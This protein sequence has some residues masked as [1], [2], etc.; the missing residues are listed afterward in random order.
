M[1]AELIGILVLLGVNLLMF[2]A[3]KRSRC[4]GHAEI[5]E[6]ISQQW[7]ILR[8]LERILVAQGVDLERLEE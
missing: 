3:G 6:S 8:R 2:L 1:S 7:K 5:V 4:E